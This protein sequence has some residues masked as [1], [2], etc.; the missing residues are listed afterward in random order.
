MIGQLSFVVGVSPLLGGLAVGIVEHAKAGAMQPEWITTTIGDQ[1]TIFV[2]APV[3][4]GG[5][6]VP[7]TLS[8]LMGREN[9]LS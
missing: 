7:K 2:I 5:L 4:V 3:L 9:R 8:A 6:C 1:Q